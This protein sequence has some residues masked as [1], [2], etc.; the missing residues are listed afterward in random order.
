MASEK[1]EIVQETGRY[2]VSIL[3]EAL[4]TDPKTVKCASHWAGAHHCSNEL[5]SALDRETFAEMWK[6]SES[7]A[8]GYGRWETPSP[9]EHMPEGDVFN[10]FTIDVP[11]Y[12]NYLLARFL[13]KGGRVVRGS[14]QHIAQIAESGRGF[15]FAPS[16]APPAAIVVCAGLGAR[17]LGGVEDANVYPVRGQTVLVRAPW[18]KHGKTLSGLDAEAYTYV[19]PRRSGLV[20]LGGTLEPDDW[21]PAPRPETTRSI[22]EHA[23]RLAPEL[24]PPH[25]RR[26][27]AD[28]AAAPCVEDV[29]PFV[30]EE[31][32]ELRPARKGGVRLEAGSVKVPLTDR[33]IP[34][35]YSYGYAGD[36]YMSSIGSAR[37]ALELLEKALSS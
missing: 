19:I 23:L 9:L 1:Q 15:G 28:A 8:E 11:V 26:A 22:L 12:L 33:T 35:V 29:L 30:V 37:V 21:N 20:T 14:V 13:S 3:A 18:I 32:C 2:R 17:F 5:W 25:L 36:G 27:G 31:G 7:E 6:L 10:T 16:P 24:V 4:P 34:V